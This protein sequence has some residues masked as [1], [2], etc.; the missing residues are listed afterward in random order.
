MKPVY[1]F[2]IEYESEFM[3]REEPTKHD[4]ECIKRGTL[5]VYRFS[6]KGDH[7]QLESLGQD[8]KWIAVPVGC[9]KEAPPELAT[10]GPYH[11]AEMD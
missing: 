3:T 2:V 4:I 7:A 8:E 1:L 11:A 5:I 9:L 10:L 6:M